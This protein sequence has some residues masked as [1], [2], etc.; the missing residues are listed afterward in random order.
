MEKK[1]PFTKVIMAAMILTNVA[2]VAFICLMMWRTNDLSPAPYL[3][4]GEGGAMITWLGS[5]AWKEKNANRSKYAME[6]V[7]KIADRYGPDVA[8]RVAE[9]VLKD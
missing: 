1:I 9:V 6:F 4:M 3:A 2:V 7:D 5:Y 8:V